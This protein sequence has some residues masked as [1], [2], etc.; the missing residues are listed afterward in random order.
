[1]IRPARADDAAFIQS[2]TP[3]FA[4][5]E[6]PSWRDRETMVRGTQ[7]QL[8]SALQRGN[9]ERSAIFVAEENGAPAG[10]AWVLLIED[11]YTREPV[12][13]VSE[14]AVVSSGKGTG[15]ALMDAC[16]RWAR[17]KGARLIVLNVLEGNVGARGF[18]S[19]LGY[20]P[21]YTM[22]AKSLGER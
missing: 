17:E 4:A 3:R 22:L 6:L 8:A 18:Y 21:E 15:S 20:A 12:G 7:A 1:M 11:F 9:G 14:I 19:K 13:K 2:L 10:F 5:F 16:E